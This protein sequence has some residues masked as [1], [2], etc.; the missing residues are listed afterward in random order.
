[1][2]IEKWK[3]HING[4][5][6][7]P[8]LKTNIITL[9][10]DYG[11]NKS[12]AFIPIRDSKIVAAFNNINNYKPITLCLD[13]EFQSAI[14]H[15]NSK[16]NKYIN[17][18]K[19]KNDKVGKFIRE[20]GFL[21]FLKDKDFKLYYI[22][23]IFLNFK[24]LTD[25]KDSGFTKKDV[26]L[27]GSK[28]ATVLP[29]TFEHMDKLETQ[30]HLEYLLDDI[31]DAW[32]NKKLIQDI[33]KQITTH[34]LFKNILNKKAQENV[35]ISF[36][37]LNEA[38]TQAAVFE[39]LKYIKRQLH[40]IQYDI[41]AKYLDKSD[42][43]NFDKLNEL[44]WNDPL[45][46]DRLKL[47]KNKYEDFMELFR[48][49]SQDSILL[50]KG[51]MDLVAL[52]NMSL[53]ILPKQEE[54]VLDNYYDIETFNGFSKTHYNSSQLEHT[55]LGLVETQ[56]YKKNKSMKKLFTEIISMI[57]DKAHNPVADSLFSIIVAVVI[58]LGLNEHFAK[59]MKGGV[60]HYRHYRHYRSEYLK[61]KNRYL[62]CKNSL[63]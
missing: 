20:L 14:I 22:G 25:F 4:L 48:L 29:E 19:V 32:T 27:I 37:K 62:T 24:P 34:Y 13:I 58:N 8:N 9:F 35:K 15:T 44:Y 61:Y 54:L 5:T 21:V 45:V 60:S 49:I 51:R 52:K 3:T 6:L 11:H 40:N 46:Q 55:Y 12:C 39:E 7:L 43:K 2:N 28:Y 36:G 38:T 16:N 26:R 42:L 30:Y 17:T 1:M 57:G 59:N 33:F 23:H 31:E 56:T 63:A 47:L 41:Y 18:D 50:V 53:L 10:S